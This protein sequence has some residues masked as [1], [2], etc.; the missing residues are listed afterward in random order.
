M[1]IRIQIKSR[2][3][4]KLKKGD[5]VS[6][7]RGKGIIT[8]INNNYARVKISEADHAWWYLEEIYK[9]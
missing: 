3:A 7:S 1:A 8:A 4:M 6:T 5:T 2:E 9:P